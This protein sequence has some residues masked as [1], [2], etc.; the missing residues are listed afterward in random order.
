M[1]IIF[2]I[3]E[4]NIFDNKK[5]K[6]IANLPYNISVILIFKWLKVS[7]KISSMTLMVQKEVA[8]RIVAKVGDK[9]YGRLSVM[10]NYLCETKI[11]FIVNNSVFKPQPKVTSA[12]IQITPKVDVVDFDEFKRLEKVVA[13]AFNQRRKML[14]KSLKS[15]FIDPT[16][17][18]EKL[19]I[20]SKLRPENLSIRQFLN[21]ANYTNSSL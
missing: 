19:G 3:D 4:S 2:K 1:R 13:V 7:D 14:K 9:N 18:L 17:S 5:F 11:N 8:Q 10:I 16:F 6:I 20:D 12:I 15:L 21:I